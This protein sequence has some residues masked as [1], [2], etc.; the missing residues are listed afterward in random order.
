MGTKRN[1]I[2]HG[3]VFPLNIDDKGGVRPETGAD[4]VESSLRTILATPINTRYTLGQ[5][6]SRLSEL[7]EEP[8]DTVTASLLDTFIREAIEKWAK[9]I[10]VIEIKQTQGDSNIIV[11]IN[12]VILA[13]QQPGSFIFPFYT[14]LTY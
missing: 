4:L 10:D 11:Q 2:G 5:F 14:Q 13:S 6:G 7:L 9:M 12:Y 3:L 1:F 8:N